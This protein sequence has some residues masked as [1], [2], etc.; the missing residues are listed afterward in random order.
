MP[1]DLILILSVLISVVIIELYRVLPDKNDLPIRVH[2]TCPFDTT[3]S[4]QAYVLSI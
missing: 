4:K 1:M 3:V 2:E